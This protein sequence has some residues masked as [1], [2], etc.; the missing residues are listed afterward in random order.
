M[1]SIFHLA[2]VMCMLFVLNQ[3]QAEEG[4]A[5][6]ISKEYGFKM[7]VPEGTKFAEKDNG[8]WAELS[9]D[10]QGVKF[11]G[12]ARLGNPVKASEIEAYGSKLTGVPSDK[13]KVIDKGENKK[14]WKWYVTVLAVHGDVAVAGGYGVGPM[15]SYMCLLK[16][17]KQDYDAHTADYNAWY[18]S[19]E[20]LNPPKNAWKLYSD[21]DYGFKMLM[22]A[23]SKITTK[24]NDSGWGELQ[25][26]KDKIKFYALCKLGEAVSAKDM[27]AYGLKITGSKAVNWKVIDKGENSKGWEWYA[28]VYA[29]EGDH[30]V[31]G[32]Y[33]VGPKGNYLCLLKTT[34]S[35]FKAH[36]YDYVTWY[37]SVMLSK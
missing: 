33:G 20:L 18:A 31:F 37:E 17:T 9:A 36:H 21:A 1:R 4:W 34:L 27:E 13:W 3:L 26:T 35:D 14:G 23:D 2:L 6:Y 5:N 32:A 19:V 11:Y 24:E 8:R 15:G 22:P 7:L 16:T 28:T 30:V 12:L 25:V 10:Y 29:H